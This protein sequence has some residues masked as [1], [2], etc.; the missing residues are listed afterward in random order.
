VT[1][2]Q[3]IP[4]VGGVGQEVLRGVQSLGADANPVRSRGGR[5]IVKLDVEATKLAFDR[6]VLQTDVELS[7]HTLLVA[8]HRDGSRIRSI[9]VADHCGLRDIEASS[10]VDAS[11][12]AT[13]STLAAVPLSQPGGP[14]AHLQPASMPVRIGGVAVG[15][16][17]DHVRLATAIR[18]HNL[19][20][21]IKIERPD[22][23]VLVRL[24][25]SQDFWWMTVDVTTDGVSA[26]DLTGAETRAREAV[27]SSLSVLRTLPGFDKAYVLS[28]GPQ[29]GIRESRRPRSRGDLC[30]DD[31]LQGR[32]RPDAVA[33]AAWPLEV[34]EAPGK[35]TFVPL[36]GAGFF[37][38]GLPALQAQDIDNLRLAGRV[39][40]CDPLAYGSLRVM[41]TAFAT[42]QAAGVSAALLADGQA[43]D[44]QRV[45]ARLLAQDAIV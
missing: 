37:D 17:P 45:R 11:G 26:G 23:G 22:G 2:E 13:L 33:R 28:T 40:G 5:W 32:R 29:L 36:G 14:G 30:G 10:F 43:D 38:V 31:G 20:A 6:I 25:I 44:A 15:V 42:G 18:E 16:E 35:C 8:V 4:A 34:H 1:G 9:T 24:P 7:L 19:Q 27:H 12:E 3:A 41:G 39:I 21:R